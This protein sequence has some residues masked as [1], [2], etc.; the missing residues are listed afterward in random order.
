MIPNLL[1]KVIVTF[2][3]KTDKNRPI[4]NEH[5]YESSQQNFNKLNLTI[6]K[7]NKTCEG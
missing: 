1:C 5:T 7:E 2:L 4:P 6:H 3:P